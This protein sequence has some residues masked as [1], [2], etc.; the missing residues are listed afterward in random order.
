MDHIQY[1][2]EHLLPGYIGR[3]FILLAMA[4]AL[5]SAFAYFRSERHPDQGWLTFGRKAFRAHSV[6]MLSVIATLFY[7]I[8]SKHYEY[9]YVAEHMNN[10]MPWQFILSCFWEGQEGSF[11]LWTFWNVVLA[12]V[13]IRT[14]RKWEGPVVGVFAVIQV[15]L[16]TMMVGVYIGEFQFGQNPFTL[17]RELPASAAS[18]FFL[19]ADYLSIFDQFKDGKGLNPLLQNYWNTIHPPIL[20]LGFA[21]TTVP[22][23]YAVAGLIRKDFRGWMAPAIPWSFFC[24]MIL[25]TGILMGGAWAYEALG[26]GGF[27]A[28][29]PVENSSL[30]PWITMV[31][32]AHLLVINKR[33]QSSLFT[34]FILVLSTFLLVLYSTFLTRS[35][36]LG[37]SS[38]HSFVDSGIL[39]QLY[40]YY[41][42]FIAGVVFLFQQTKKHRIGYAATCILALILVVALQNVAPMA[43][44]TLFIVVSIAW[45]LVAYVK[46][47]KTADEENLW[48]REF[49]MFIGAIVLTLAAVHISL[50][51]SIPVINLVMGE[52]S[53]PYQFEEPEDIVAAYH[54]FQVP[55]AILISVLMGAT[56]YFRYGKTDMR[57]FGLNMLFGLGAALLATAGVIWAEDFSYLEDKRVVFLLG[58]AVFAVVANIDYAVRILKGRINFSGANVA[59]VGFGMVLIGATLSTSQKTFIS[60]NDFG[61]LTR[62][63]ED[64]SNAES[65]LMY[66]GD[67]LGMG[68][69]F[70]MYKD[71]HWLPD[72]VHFEVEVDYFASTPRTYKQNDL[73]LS[74]GAIF[75]C[76]QDHK[77][78]ATFLEDIETY[79]SQ[80]PM[81]NQR[82]LRVAR[83]WHPGVPGEY[84]FTLNPSLIR[85]DVMGST[86][87]EPS[88][89]HYPGRDVYTY[90]N[91]VDYEDPVVDDRGY[92]EARK[93]VLSLGNSLSVSG[94]VIQVDSVRRITEGRPDILE[95][96]DTFNIFLSANRKEGNLAFSL[97]YIALRGQVLAEDYFLEEYGL[98]LRL[99]N[100]EHERRELT[101]QISEHESVAKDF[102]VMSAIIFPQIN[103]LWLGC[104]VMVIGTI[105]AILHRIREFRRR[106]A[107]AKA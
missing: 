7:L 19:E 71:K 20:F 57:R 35:G 90:L 84:L 55:F 32:G 45:A 30:V 14:S 102:I 53:L 93:H 107:K 76:I 13:L 40:F 94:T 24:I 79:W 72:S 62:L 39:P 54:R 83:P 66:R 74:K 36:V 49:W 99:E 38:V 22:F 61:D 42:F 56:H 65:K 81:P 27:W 52:L 95:D 29:D 92:L 8:I 25:G 67:T 12:N 60:Q 64:F 85:N 103:I 17:V 80:V 50:R 1:L 100:Y 58:A 18:S 78:S 88:I 26:F 86:S 82:Q 2:G 37:D 98:R 15:F 69:Y 5:M 21:S 10:T 9:Y 91:F 46:F 77:A 48:S 23:C 47:P 89:K 106:D 59:H 101:I 96:E 11:L 3:A 41:L 28:W 63:S 6:F 68:E 4:T 97:P 16:T 105:I 87:R 43:I 70:V 34:A 73:A 31:A 104:L 75:L 44:T 33:K 51:N